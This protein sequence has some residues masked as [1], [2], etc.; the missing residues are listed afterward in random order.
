M[1][2]RK[3]VSVRQRRVSAELRSLRRDRGLSCKDVAVGVDCSE[4]KISRMETGDRGLYAD[5]VATV[6]G[7][8]QCP[9]AKR[10]ELLALVR[11]G[12]ERNWHEIHGKLPTNWHDLIRFENEATAICN[13]EP[14]IVP[15]LAQ[16]PDYSRAI[17]HGV[18]SRLSESEVENLVAARMTRQVIFSRRQAPVVHLV[19]DEMVLR[20]PVGGVEVMRTQLRHLLHLAERPKVSLQ[21]VPFASGAHPGLTGPF[22]LLESPGSP[23]LAYVESRGTSSFLEEGEHVD[24]VRVA[25]RELRAIALSPEDSGRLIASVSSE[26]ITPEERNP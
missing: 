13:Y 21:V 15:G 4:S 6:L 14:I 1:S 20:R 3:G 16:V 10:Q 25:W 5:D 9:A 18:N 26:L 2:K 7:F 22:V 19:I 11:E 23:A 24:S 17:M 8:L 12:E